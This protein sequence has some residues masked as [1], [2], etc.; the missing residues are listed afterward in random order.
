MNTETEEKQAIGLRTLPRGQLLVTFGGVLLA[1]FLSSLDQT[2]VG[3][4]MPRIIAD[5]GG[6]AHYTWIATAYLLT[7]TVVMPIIGK[8]T[9]L[10]GRKNFYI[11]GVAVFI[12]GSLLCGLSQTMTQIIFYRGLQGIGAG[13][14]IANAFAVI[15][16]IFPPAERGKYQGLV[17]AVFGIAAIVGPLL[18]GFLT[19]SFSWH[20]IFYIN[21]PLGIL[22]I[23]LFTFFFPNF[24]LDTLK[25]RIDY[26]GITTLIV[27]V[28]PLLLALSWGGVEYPWTSVQVISMFVLAVAAIIAFPFVE[29]RSEEPIVP[30]DIFRNPIVA[31][32]VPIIFLAGFSMYSAIIFIPLFFQGVL[33][34]SATASGSFITPMV[35]GQVVGSFISGQLISRTGGHYRI[36]GI[37]G[38][39][40][41]IAG[42]ALL[43]RMTPETTFGSALVNI[44][45]I[46]F[47]L[48]ITLP[49]YTIAVQNAVSYNVLGAA[50][51]AVPFFRS[52]GGAVGLAIFGS[53]MTSRFATDFTAKLPPAIG[54]LIPPQAIS[55]MANNPQALV[56][57]EAQAQLQ[58]LLSQGGQGRNLYEQTL[59]LLRQ[60]LMSGLNE[61]FFICL[62]VAVIAFIVNLFIKEIPLRKQHSLA[63]STDGED[64]A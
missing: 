17:G 29:G 32:S 7:S 55:A 52:M 48:G 11:A 21:I 35:L 51:S 27:A 4:A 19:D 23:I 22:V 64:K 45:L 50:T 42:L 33:G 28:V 10:Y 13:I 60:A 46:G 8:L 39:A 37:F 25:H 18:G 58:L 12:I 2:I 34:V 9:D 61:V 38:I 15:G 16:D 14:M 44:V 49:L 57:P 5:L 6:F 3:T 56:S 26:P 59:G 30:L 53:V 1:I 62:I 36:Q 41:M 20:W 47:G 40:L 31:I 54:A 24:R 43:T 63:E